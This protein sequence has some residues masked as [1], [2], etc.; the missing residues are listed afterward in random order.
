MH[1][2]KKV[3]IGLSE[4]AW[5]VDHDENKIRFE[6]CKKCYAKIAGMQ[7]DSNVGMKYNFIY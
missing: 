6:L 1:Y 7:T 2:S 3:R 4:E 5:E